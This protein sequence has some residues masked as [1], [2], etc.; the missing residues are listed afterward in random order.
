MRN[1]RLPV[2][3]KDATCTITDTVS[4]TNSPPMMR[5]TISWR[6]MAA[7]RPSAAPKANAPTSPMMTCAG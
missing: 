7:T 3:L 6:T 2:S 4:M 1:T 5:S